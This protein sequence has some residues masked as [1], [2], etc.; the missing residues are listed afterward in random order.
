MRR[1][2]VFGGLFGL[3]CIGVAAAVGGCQAM[4]GGAGEEGDGAPSGDPPVTEEVPAGEEFVAGAVTWSAEV[5]DARP[6]FDAG[7]VAQSS[8]VDTNRRTADRVSVTGSD[9]TLA[10]HVE[11]PTGGPPL[12]L[13]TADAIETKR[14]DGGT[15][16]VL[17]T[18]VG[19]QSTAYAV[20]YELPDRL[21]DLVLGHWI[22]QHGQGQSDG[23]VFADSSSCDVDRM[24]RS[25]VRNYAGSG[26]GMVSIEEGGVSQQTVLRGLEVSR[27]YANFDTRQVHANV[28]DGGG[29]RRVILTGRMSDDRTRFRG[30]VSTQIDGV[31]IEVGTWGGLFC[32]ARTGMAAASASAEDGGALVITAAYEYRADGRDISAMAV[33]EA[34]QSSVEGEADDV[35]RDSVPSFG[36]LSIAD[37]NYTKGESIGP[38]ALP[39]AVGGDGTVLYGL[40]QVPDGLSFSSSSRTLTGTPT[41][42]GTYD[43]RYTAQDSDGDEATLNFTVTVTDPPPLGAGG[44]D[45]DGEADDDGSGGDDDGVS[46]DDDDG[47]SDD[48]GTGGDDDGFSSDDDDGDR[49]DDGSGGDDDGFDSDDDDGLSDDDGTGG[50]DDGFVDDDDDGVS[51]DDGSGGDDDGSSSDD[52][53]GT[54]DDDGSGGDD[55]GFSSDDDDGLS[56]DDGSGG[57]DDGTSSDDDDGTGDDDGSGGDD[58][59]FSSDDDDGLSDDDGSSSDDD[60]GTGDD[61]GDDN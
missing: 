21:F 38:L 61:D 33:M 40:S 46:T 30:V 37:Q 39:A 57:D 58:D 52:D 22:V 36:G 51:D 53:D 49:D 48:D 3:L 45:D 18:D 42:S 34:Q 32:T 28:L 59:G 47:L 19:G 56:D 4:A 6:R 55:D 5:V 26:F 10:V 2:R 35:V 15:R 7:N 25:D 20:T 9:D 43:I 17:Q 13:A 23:G 44:D 12:T 41:R 1:V 27:F 29:A 60:D 11:G 14:I 8:N 31:L 16:R 54:G 24:S 50:D